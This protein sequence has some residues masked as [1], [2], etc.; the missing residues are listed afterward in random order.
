[1]TD[2]V[3]VVDRSANRGSDAARVIGRAV[4][5]LAAWVGNL[6]RWRLLVSVGVRDGDMFLE[7]PR[8]C[9][10]VRVSG[11]E[12]ARRLAASAP[13]GPGADVAVLALDAQ[14]RP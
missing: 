8:G 3:F 6:R 5:D 2:F 7:G 1:V 12:A 11:M 14:D 13:L 4:D 10:V 9:L